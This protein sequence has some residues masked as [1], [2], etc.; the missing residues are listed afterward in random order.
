MENKEPIRVAQMVGK[1]FGGGVESVVMNYYRHIDRSK[2]QFDFICDEESTDIPYKEIESLGGR[3][4][5]IPKYQKV[6]QYHR[7]LKKIFKKENYKIVHSHINTLSVFSLFAAKCAGV[8]VRIAHSHSTTNK[9]EKKKNLLK[10]LLRPFSKVFATDYMCCSEL[11]G[12][13][14]FGNKEYDKG[15]VYLLNNAIDLDKFKYD[16]KIRNE[17][18]KELNIDDDTLV[19]GHVGR[20]VEQKNHRF[21]IDI[22]NEVHKEKENSILMLVGQ[23]PLMEEIKEK[24]KTLGLEKNVMFLGQRSDVADLYQAF[25]VFCLPSLYEG[26]PVVGVEA[27]ATGL[28]CLFSD[29]MTKE[30]KVL[31]TT[32]FLSL[33]QGVKEWRK[34]IFEKLKSYN[35]NNFNAESMYKRYDIKIES[36]RI[37]KKYYDFLDRYCYSFDIFDSLVKR[38]INE[39]RFFEVI[40]KKLCK[41]GI[42]I[43]KYSKRRRI[44]EKKLNKSKKNYTIKQIY[45]EFEELSKE[46]ECAAIALEKEYVKKNMIPNS[47]GIKIFNKCFGKKI[48]IS[49]M[50]LDGSYLKE[51]LEINRIKNISEIFVSCDYNGRSKKN[52]KL[53]N[54]VKKK[55]KINRHFGDAIRSD[56][57][58]AKISGIS[59]RKIK[60]QKTKYLF[61]YDMGTYYFNIGVNVFGPLIYEFNNWLKIKLDQYSKS[62]IVFLAREGY[63]LKK[64][65]EKEFDK[66][67]VLLYVSR[68]SI[69]IG[70]SLIFINKYDFEKFKRYFNLSKSITL[71]EF[72]IKIGCDTIRV[73]KKYELFLSN[74]MT[75]KLYNELRVDD[76][77]VKLLKYNNLRFEKYIM[78]FISKENILIDVGW[79]G[80]MQKYLS[81]YFK[82]KKQEIEFYG[83][84][85]GCMNSKNK[86][87]FLFSN[88]NETYN[89]IMCFS[90]L[91]ENIFMPSFGT[92]IN[93]DE[94]G[95]PIFKETEF[96]NESQK[97]ILEIQNGMDFFISKMMDFENLLHLNKEEVIN[98]LYG[99]GIFPTEE[100][101][102]YF[103]KIELLDGENVNNLIDGNDGNFFKKFISSKWKTAFLKKR[104]KLKIDYSIIISK[105][106]KMKK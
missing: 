27:Q 3:V 104:L 55:Y 50:Y 79:N 82:L 64:A 35:R 88:T 62:N 80:S 49:D 90:G 1:W 65:F 21:L 84:Y 63:Y 74:V 38:F 83:L 81:D 72:L 44:I 87:G 36:N 4:F 69:V 17:K 101:I 41:I 75:C 106:R 61:N 28:L 93:Y 39:K 54:T 8:P 24:V 7:E 103:N 51:L 60:K 34:K 30:T 11:A 53:Y 32:E 23:G 13:W 68:K 31:D 97:I 78:R 16:E 102:K 85:L 18:R 37:V 92:T 95:K 100:E 26:L 105:M 22:F 99:L 20:F 48:C 43:D 71:G 94:D 42:N 76:D 70:T 59:S 66:K 77:I 40:E 33:E 9:K 45:D 98:N 46:Q 29:D 73:K 96:S 2:V 89:K 86:D 91:L 67:S 57:I 58:N 14:L 6:I 47:E 56:W 10:Q 52:R 5:L 15:N 19:I 25:D 12:R